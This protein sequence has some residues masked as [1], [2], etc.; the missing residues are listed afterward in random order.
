[1]QEYA[2]L[3]WLVAIVVVFWLL[4]IRPNQQRQKAAAELQSS[5]AVGDRVMLTSGIHAVVAELA[6]EHVMVEVAPGTTLKVARGAVGAKLDADR[7]GPAG[8]ESAG[9]G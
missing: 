6:D 4:I 7:T 8:D 5:L 3:L 9:E 2:W 1:M